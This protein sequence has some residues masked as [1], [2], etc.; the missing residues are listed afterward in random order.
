MILEVQVNES[1]IRLDKA[2][3]DSLKDY[4]R[5]Q[6]QQW[7][8]SGLVTSD[9]AKVKASDKS[10]QG[11]RISIDLPEAPDLTLRAEPIELDIVYEDEHLM[12]INKP[13]GM[14]VHPGAGHHSGTLVNA[15]LY[16]NQDDLSD[17][18]EADRPGIV[19][20]LDKDT[21]GLLLV[22]KT[23]LAH[24]R[25]G[26]Q[27]QKHEIVRIYEAIVYGHFGEKAGFIDA[28][29]A[30]D[31]QNRQRMQVAPD[32]RQAR[33]HFRLLESLKGSSY[34]RVKLETGRTHQ[35]RVHMKFIDHP[36]LADPIYAPN[37]ENFG[38]K[39]QCLHAGEIAF[40]HPITGEKLHFEAALPEWFTGALAKLGYDESQEIAWPAEWPDETD[41]E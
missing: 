18:Y 7:L 12:V 16:H 9:G 31:K 40:T 30:R 33:T 11:Q 37:R 20:R 29:I 27:L 25:L 26:A 22:A 3:A 38:L 24:R 36:V 28:P 23:N 5:S 32:G 14:V 10:Y 2:I 17:G 4:S 15:L 8:K 1:G 41:Y 21:S 6:V 34:I 13:Q 39:G 35:I 19:H